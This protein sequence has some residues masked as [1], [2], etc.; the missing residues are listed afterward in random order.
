M[1]LKITA[2]LVATAGLYFFSQDT[3]AQ[4][5]DLPL[6]KEAWEAFSNVP[7]SVADPEA[8]KN[9]MLRLAQCIKPSALKQIV[10]K[11][12]QDVESLPG[13]DPDRKKVILKSTIVQ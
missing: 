12:A 6:V 2:T 7:G 9:R 3:F 10:E 4:T 5:P 11:I 1:R 13:L 8:E